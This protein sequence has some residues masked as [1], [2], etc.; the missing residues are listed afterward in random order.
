MLL[1]SGS[2]LWERGVSSQ[3]PQT[4]TVGPQQTP[5]PRKEHS[6][7]TPCMVS[8]QDFRAELRPHLL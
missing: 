4:A 6:P 5:A 1:S 3:T 8:Q 2:V 7:A